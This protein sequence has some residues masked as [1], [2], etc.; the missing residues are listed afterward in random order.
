MTNVGPEVVSSEE[1]EFALEW[2]R[3]WYRGAVYY[4]SAR[5]ALRTLGIAD[6]EMSEL[7]ASLGLFLTEELKELREELKEVKC[8]WSCIGEYED[9][10][11]LWTTR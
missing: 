6:I 10:K 1:R 5:K 2:A 3:E 8:P 7:V 4:G 11:K 9:R